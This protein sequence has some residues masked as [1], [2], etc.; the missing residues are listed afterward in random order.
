MNTVIRAEGL[1]FVY[2]WEKDREHPV[3]EK[4]LDQVDLAI[5]EGQSIVILGENG[6]GKSTLARC[7]NALLC[8]T[9]GRVL[10]RGMDTAEEQNLYAIRST[11][12]I[13]FQNPDNQIVSSIVEEDVAFGPENLGIPTEEI[14]LRV[15]RALKDVGLYEMRGRSTYQLSGGQKQR[16]AIAGVLAMRPACMIFD[17]S[18]AM[19]DPRGRKDVLNIMEQLRAERMTTI[20]ITH[21]MEEAV[22]ADRVLIMKKGKIIADEPPEK[23]FSREELVREAGLELPPAI[24][25][26]NLLRR[27]GVPVP[28]R[29]LGMEALADWLCARKKDAGGGSHED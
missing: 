11:V 10:V 8:P 21:F 1:S 23:I 19:L 9:G 20:L 12:G 4:V 13:V 5:E 14:R 7:L 2:G 28:D 27:N 22:R 26:R 18:T 15:D 6:S 17:E 29:I 25:I 3:S 16:I 24:R